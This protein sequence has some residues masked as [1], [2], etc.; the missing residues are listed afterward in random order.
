MHPG[1]S[2]F[3]YEGTLLAHVVS[4]NVLLVLIPLTKLS[5][6]VLLPATQV[7]SE[8]AWFFPSDAGRKVAMVLEKVDEPI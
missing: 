6:M 4:A 5:H 2:P 7:V 3:P 1:F 8:L